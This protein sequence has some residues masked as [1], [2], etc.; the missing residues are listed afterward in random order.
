MIHIVLGTK[1]QLI[2]MAPV[3][4]EFN[5][6]GIEYNFVFTGQHRET[7]DSILAIFDLKQPNI[8]LYK[9]KE[10]TTPFGVLAWFLRV[11]AVFL[12]NKKK[13]WQGDINGYVL[14]HGDTLSTLLGAFFAKLHG[15]KACHV[16]SG[17]RSHSLMHPFPE[18]IIRILVF[19]FSDYYFC[20]GKLATNNVSGYSGVKVN[21]EINTLYDALKIALSGKHQVSVEIPDQRYSIVSIHRFEN[22]FDKVR[23]RKI[24]DII[25]KV[26]D[27]YT[28]LFVLHK[29]TRRQLE[30]LGLFESLNK[31]PNILLRDRYDYFKFIKLIEQSECVLT[32]GGSNQEECSFLGKPCLIL[33]KHTERDDGLNA[34]AVLCDLDLS[35][36]LD[37]MH[38]ISDYIRPGAQYSKSPSTIIVDTVTEN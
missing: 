35:K 6:R 29:P 13:L 16:E 11:C 9:H 36:I 18:E 30:K 7:I 3:M 31:H 34:S 32:D 10:S 20:P 23:F 38:N 12:F 17:L 28:L 33:R 15:H 4:S 26:A 1:A 5:S 25:L 14:N 19:K 37:V 2:K 8:Q 27:Q 21:T 24:V 22:I